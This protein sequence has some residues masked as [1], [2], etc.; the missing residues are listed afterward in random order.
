MTHEYGKM[1]VKAIGSATRHIAVTR[2]CQWVVFHVSDLT[3]HEDG[4]ESTVR[5]DGHH[6]TY[7][8][9][10][11]GEWENYRGKGK[12][13]EIFAAVLIPLSRTSI[14]D[15]TASPPREVRVSLLDL[16]VRFRW[17]CGL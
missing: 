11:V 1:E 2:T 12:R 6:S 15:L 14:Q 10:K 8:R 9:E 13:R 5:K 3:G 17:I 4:K 7:P 16:R